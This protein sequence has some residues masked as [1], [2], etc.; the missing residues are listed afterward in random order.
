MNHSNFSLAISLCSVL[1][2]ASCASEPPP[3]VLKS[4]ELP[5]FWSEAVPRGGVWPDAEWWRQFNSPELDRL[6]AEARAANLDLAAATARVLQSEAQVR[7]ARAALFPSVQGNSVLQNQGGTSSS[8][9][10]NTLSALGVQVAYEFDFWGLARNNIR[11]AQALLKSARYSGETVALTVT[12]DVANTYFQILA[13][14]ERTGVALQNLATAKRIVDAIQI[15][16]DNGLSS[17]LD[18][19]QQQALAAGQAA[20]IPAL[21]QQEKEDRYRLGTLL[22][23]TPEGF[24]IQG[25]SLSRIAVPT[26]A[27]GLPSEL[28]SR[29]PD[30]AQAE[31]NLVAAN[32]N[33]QVARAAFFPAISL[34][35]F[36]ALTGGAIPSA[37]NL[38]VGEL[39]AA[40]GAG[41][42]YTAGASLLQTIFDAGRRQGQLDLAKDQ[43]QEL[44][45]NYR[46]AVVKAFSEVE[47]ALNQTARLAEQEMLKR[48][49]AEKAARAFD[50]SDVEY[51]EGLIDLLALLQTQQALFAAQ[52]HLLEVRLARFQAAISLYK[53][54]G[55]GWSQAQEPAAQ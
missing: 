33:I 43:Q 15:R 19:A 5:Q 37:T 13:L 44:V 45:A 41:L 27:P 4:Q 35:V 50:I 7:I 3:P 24:S 51:R 1:V 10:E 48:E 47:N 12:A 17:P 38:A 6:I 34:S 32:A 55:G 28:V 29:R 14:R 54:L 18:L 46:G 21:Q 42:I 53:A 25:Q 23:Q 36:P 20:Q 30:I 52:D 16:S 11:A 9:P 31:A 26:L 22:G 2:L 39:S 40:G 49:E 8:V